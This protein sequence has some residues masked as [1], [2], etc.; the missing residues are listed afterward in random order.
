MRTHGGIP[1]VS[2]GKNF[3]GTTRSC[4]VAY[5]WRTDARRFSPPAR[6]NLILVHVGWRTTS[7][8]SW[9]ARLLLES[10]PSLGPV[11]ARSYF[12]ERKRECARACVCRLYTLASINHIVKLMPLHQR[13]SRPKFLKSF[14]RKNNVAGRIC[15]TNL[16]QQLRLIRK[17]FGTNFQTDMK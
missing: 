9:N 1:A 4:A 15:V 6:G 7:I 3:H 8:P 16:E 14:R 2:R 13:P 5:P 11:S 17:A 12:K 10:S